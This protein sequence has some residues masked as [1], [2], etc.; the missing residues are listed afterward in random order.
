MGGEEEKA[1]FFRYF[2]VADFQDWNGV[3]RFRAAHLDG[4]ERVRNESGPNR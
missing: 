1:M 4:L 2:R 3:R